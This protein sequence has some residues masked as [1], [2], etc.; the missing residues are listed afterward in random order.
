M[1]RRMIARDVIYPVHAVRPEEITATALVSASLPVAEAYAAE[2]STD[3]GVLAGAVTRFVIDSPGERT[4]VALFVGGTRQD[5]PTSP[6]T[7]RYWQM[8]TAPARLASYRRADQC[9]ARWMACAAW[10]ITS[11]GPARRGWGLFAG[12]AV[13]VFAE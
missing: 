1:G 8:G 10:P 11:N 2:L 12:A 7:A 5:A 13:D 9:S 4:A 3:P 6:T